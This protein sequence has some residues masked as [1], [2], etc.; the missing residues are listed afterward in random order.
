MPKL[1][2]IPVK[3]DISHVEIIQDF[4]VVQVMEP[5]TINGKFYLEI[6]ALTRMSVKKSPSWLRSKEM[7]IEP[8]AHVFLV[9]CCL[10]RGC[11]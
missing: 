2:Q 8:E 3:A 5:H 11:I 7:E 4:M 10:N 9:N 6:L 1:P